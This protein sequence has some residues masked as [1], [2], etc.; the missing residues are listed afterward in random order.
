MPVLRRDAPREPQGELLP[1]VRAAPVG[2]A[3]LPGLRRRDGRGLALLRELRARHGLRVRRCRIA[4]IPGDG[5]G[6]EVIDAALGPIERAATKHGVTLELER[7]PYGADHYLKP[8]KRS[9]TERS[10]ICATT[11]TP[12]CWERSETRGYRATST[13]GTSCWDS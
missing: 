2:G 8:R 11:R 13:R 9:Q 7:L 10:T 5:I 6:P 3:A 12:S 1:A 4:V